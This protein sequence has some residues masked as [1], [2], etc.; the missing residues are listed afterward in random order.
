MKQWQKRIFWTVWI[1]YFAYYLCRYNMPMAKTRLCETFQWDTA[2][3]GM[4]LSA[5]T[6]AYA[7]GQFV[8]GQLADRFG[9]R[10]MA[11]MGVAGS[12]AMNLLIF[13]VLLASMSKNTISESVLWVLVVLWGANG[14]F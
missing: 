5:L 13:G 3:F 8:S 11:S 1:T 6:V 14:F 12:V 4:I 10:L 7:V 9:A 2:Q